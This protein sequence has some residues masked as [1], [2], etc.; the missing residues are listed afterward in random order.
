MRKKKNP[1]ITVPLCALSIM[2]FPALA[3]ADFLIKSVRNTE[4]VTIMGMT[5]PAITEQGQTWIRKYISLTILKIHIQ[6]SIY[7]LTWKNYYPPRLN[8][9]FR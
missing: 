7:L 2:L 4:E 8:K 1:W 9:Y 3:K 6:K 5:Q